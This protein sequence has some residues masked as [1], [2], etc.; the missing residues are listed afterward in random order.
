MNYENKTEEELISILDERD[1][2][3]ET[4]CEEIDSLQQDNEE[5]SEEVSI[6]STELSLFREFEEEKEE[7]A[8]NAFDSGFD[9]GVNGEQ[10]LKSWLNFKI[11]ARL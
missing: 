1:E 3:I 4:L 7:F 10:K 5:L 9:S 2:N 11:G 8:N 6:I